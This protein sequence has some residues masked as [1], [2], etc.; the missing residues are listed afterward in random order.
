M[1]DEDEG[2][3]DGEREKREDENPL[4]APDFAH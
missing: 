2:S 4:A 3:D 1:R